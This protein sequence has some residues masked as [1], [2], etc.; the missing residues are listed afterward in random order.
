MRDFAFSR[1]T[2]C[3]QS[4]TVSLSGHRVLASRCFRSSISESGIA[5]VKGRTSVVCCAVDAL[6]LV[7]LKLVDGIIRCTL[8]CNLSH[9]TRLCNDW[10]VQNE[11][12]RTRAMNDTR[13][14]ILDVALEVLG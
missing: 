2:P 5:T 4:E 8:L 1:R 13:N 7:L 12:A 14:R 9:C 10:L 6:M 3:D 11:S